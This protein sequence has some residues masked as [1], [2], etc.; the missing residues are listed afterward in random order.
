MADLDPRSREALL[1]RLD[2]AFRR[3]DLEALKAALPDNA[4]PN[5]PMPDTI[6]SCL[7][8]AIYW[9]PLAF[10]R[11]LLE[12]GADPNASAD[13]GFPPLIAALAKS[14]SVPGSLERTDVDEIIELLLT[15]GAD[16]NQRGIN[17]WTPLHMAVAERNLL[18][19]QRLLD[20]GADADLRT[21]ID[22]HET[23]GEMARSAGLADFEELIGRRG[24][25]LGKRLRAGVTLLTDIAGQGEAVRR[26]Q[27]YRARLRFWLADGTRV[28]WEHAFGPVGAA[29]LDDGG[30]TMVTTIYVNRGQLINGLFYGL[31]GMRVGG[32]RRLGLAAY[33]AYGSRGIPGTVPPGSALTIE[34][35]ILAAVDR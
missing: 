11:T 4:V 22:D 27:A 32:M 19:V 9:S 8:Y 13:D 1:G 15:F 7:V 20:A 3:G 33:M 10:V 30:G 12:H 25:P 17:D 34:V 28:R 6:G 24:R 21:R 23:P 16:P 31:D 14:R 26:Q 29:E 18:A 2:D 35:R 5:G